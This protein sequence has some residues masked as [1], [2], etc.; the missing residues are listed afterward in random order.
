MRDK[1]LKRAVIIGASIGALVSLGAALSMDIVLS[2]TFQ[3]S[4]WDA[5]ARDV[6]RMFGPAWG[7]NYFAVTLL[8]VSVMVF[9]VGFGAVLGAAGGLMMNIFFKTVLK[10]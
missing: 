5:A 2:D 4:W 8:L 9:L 1:G 6:T 3:G 7:Q 10:L